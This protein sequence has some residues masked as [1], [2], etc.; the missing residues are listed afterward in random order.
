MEQAFGTLI[1]FGNGRRSSG[2]EF[3]FAQIPQEMEIIQQAWLCTA[4]DE[5]R[6]SPKDNQL[7]NEALNHS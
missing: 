4:V 1:A 6:K 5:F 2:F 3:N 7:S